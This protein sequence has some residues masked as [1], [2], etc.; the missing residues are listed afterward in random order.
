VSGRPGRSGP[1]PLELLGRLAL[2]G[3]GAA[4]LGRE[5]DLARS[6]GP[7][8][9]VKQVRDATGRELA[10]SPRQAVYRGIWDDAAAR[11]GAD[12]LERP[13]GFL[14]I[15]NGTGSIR[16]WRH[17][18]PVDDPVTLRLAGDKP[19]AHVVLTEAGLPVPAYRTVAVGA[20]DEA[21]EFV[22]EQGRVVVK[23]ASSTGAGSGVTGGVQTRADL[24]RARV[25]AARHDSERLLLERHADGEEYRVLV[26]DG[27]PIGVVRREPPR[28]HGD[29]ASTV[30]ELAEAENARRR[31]ARGRAGL[32]SVHLDLDALIA[33]RSQSLTIRSRP[34]AGQLVTLKSTTSEG[35]E[36]DAAVVA[37]D[38]P[39]IAGIVGDAAKAATA[40]GA[41]LASVEMVTPD[42]SVP[43]AEAGGVIVEVNTTPGIAQHYLVSNP[44]E[45]VPVAETVLRRLLTS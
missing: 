16:L 34:A 21:S 44:D 13:P 11:I 24:L 35:S 26:L 37:L 29:G 39:R 8:R 3:K 12:V 19:A 7:S 38:E 23:P 9:Y 25:S 33:L 15:S 20:L 2:Y 36:R 30:A 10:G 14:T 42:P 4:A 18:L 27:E 28:V 22:R 1:F 31:R 32:W 45:I 41:R 6:L 17:L 40:I 43:L 5:L